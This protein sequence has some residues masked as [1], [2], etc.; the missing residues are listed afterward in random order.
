MRKAINCL[1]RC[2]NHIQFYSDNTDNN[3]I[4]NINNINT[5]LIFEISGL[6]PYDTMCLFINNCINKNIDEVD[7]NIIFFINNAYSLT[8]QLYHMI[9]IINKID[10]NK[11][12]TKMK[13]L[14]IENIILIDNHLL[15]G[16]DEY[17][18]YTNLAYNIM[19]IC[20]NIII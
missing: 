19:N 20:N 9:E 18:Q 5:N 2:K 11:L 13:S 17:I 4:N 16:C 10:D 1:Q 15:N 8:I 7:N 12:T 3:N 14:I 6:I